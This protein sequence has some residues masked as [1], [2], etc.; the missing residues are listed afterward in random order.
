MK[1][2]FEGDGGKKEGERR[3]FEKRRK[4]R[5]SLLVGD[6]HLLRARRGFLLLLVEFL[7]GLEVDTKGGSL[8]VETVSLGTVLLE[9]ALLGKDFLGLELQGSGLGCRDGTDHLAELLQLA[10]L[11]VHLLLLHRSDSVSH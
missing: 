6:V 2:V 1:K 11:L 5:G 9:L 10:Q 7:F 4:E 3:P 8:G